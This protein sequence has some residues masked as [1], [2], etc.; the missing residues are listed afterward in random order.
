ML[1][2]PVKKKYFMIDIFL[3]LDVAFVIN[4]GNIDIRVY[5]KHVV[6]REHKIRDQI[7]VTIISYFT[8]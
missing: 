8:Q 1:S 7:V 2:K 4:L 3:W 6:D 5:Q